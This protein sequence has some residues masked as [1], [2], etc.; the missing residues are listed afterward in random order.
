[1]FPKKLNQ[2]LISKYTGNKYPPSTKKPVKVNSS[3]LT[4]GKIASYFE[5]WGSKRIVTYRKVKIMLS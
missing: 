2:G 1:M 3:F 4:I 5:K